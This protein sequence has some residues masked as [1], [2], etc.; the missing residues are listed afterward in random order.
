MSSVVRQISV[1]SQEQS[2][3]ISQVNRAV[4]QLDIANQQNAALVEETAAS[5]KALDDQAR[6]M[7]SMVETFNTGT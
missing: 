5:S 6:E 4:N 2:D 1:A 3:G 7:L